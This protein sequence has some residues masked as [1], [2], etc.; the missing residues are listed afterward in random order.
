MPMKSWAMAVPLSLL[1]VQSV[2]AQESEGGKLLAQ[3]MQFPKAFQD[4][5]SV[6]VEN[7]E[8]RKVEDDVAK[9]PGLLGALSLAIRIGRRRRICISAC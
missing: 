3:E 6:C 1:F 8:Q 9:T 7:A 4:A 5:I 2:C